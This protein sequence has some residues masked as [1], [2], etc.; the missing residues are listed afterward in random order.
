MARFR[1]VVGIGERD[2]YRWFYD[3]GCRRY[4]EDLFKFGVEFFI[5]SFFFI[6][7]FRFDIK[8]GRSFFVRARFT[9][10]DVASRY[11]VGSSRRFVSYRRRRVVDGR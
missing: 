6:F 11:V 5:K 3:D 1:D 4:F 8:Y 9:A 7:M 10:F 2:Y